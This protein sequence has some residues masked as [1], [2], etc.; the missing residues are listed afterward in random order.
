VNAF[1]AELGRKLADRWLD[2]LVLPGL[3]WFAA[4]VA[5]TRLGQGHPFDA[6]RLREWLDWEAAQPG[7][8]SLAAVLAAVL[9]VLAAAAAAGLAASGL[10]GLL[11]RLW[12]LPGWRWPLSR[13]VSARQRRWQRRWD[14][15]TATLKKAIA[16]EANPDAHRQEL[17][18]AARQLRAAEQ[19][20]RALGKSWPERPTRI[21]DLFYSTAARL[22][23]AYGLEDLD[24][25]WPRLWSVLPE[26]MRTDLATAQDAYTAAAR[27]TAWGLLYAVLAIAWW[28]A[29]VIGAA[30]AVTG[31]L[32][33]CSAANVLADLID[34][35]TDLH[36]GDLAAKLGIPANLPVTTVT[37]RAIIR[38]LRKTP[39]PTSTN[40]PGGDPTATPAPSLAEPS[41]PCESSGMEGDN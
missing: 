11:Q 1:L 13:V 27:L 12:V 33:G 6:V 9:G 5:A 4:L 26:T 22:N 2:L 32:Q 25:V 17:S 41:T 16:V 36:T 24:L 39:P 19:Q 30:V 37:G 35:A 15:A 23:I 21:A 38:L 7:S 31:W 14:K 20:R 18:K 34:T 40:A 3:L 29:F 28:P 10:G 8:H